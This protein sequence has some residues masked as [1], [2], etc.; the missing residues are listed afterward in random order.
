M[1]D[2]LGPLAA[3]VG[4]VAQITQNVQTIANIINTPRKVIITIEN[5]TDQILQY[6][7]GPFVHGDFAQTPSTQIPPRQANTFGAQ[8]RAFSIGT[9]VEGKVRY[10]LPDQT[11]FELYVDNPFFGQNNGGVSAY[12]IVMKKVAVVPGFT[13]DLPVQEESSSWITTAIIGAGNT[14]DSRFALRAAPPFVEG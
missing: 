10:V 12:K 7:D 9:G 6:V 8:S 14:S 11:F 3:A 1:P 2:V 13:I 5:F 4:D